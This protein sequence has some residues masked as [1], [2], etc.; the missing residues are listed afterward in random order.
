MCS[1]PATCLDTLKCETC[2]RQ[3]KLYENFL[4]GK[5]ELPVWDTGAPMLV[6]VRFHVIAS[7]AGCTPSPTDNDILAM[8]GQMNTAFAAGS[9]VFTHSIEHVQSDTWN[10]I[11]CHQEY[12]D[13]LSIP[14]GQ[15]LGNDPHAIDVYFVDQ[16]LSEGC[17]CTGAGPT[18]CVSSA[19]VS[20]FSPSLVQGVVIRNCG[21]EEV[22]PCE[23]AFPSQPCGDCP[24]SCGTETPKILV[25]EVGHY[26]DL[27]HPHETA[28][29]V[30]CPAINEANCT[31]CGDFLCDTPAEPEPSAYG[32]DP[33]SC[34]PT[35]LP[36]PPNPPCG[37]NAPYTPDL[38]NYMNQKPESALCRNHFTRGQLRRARATLL[39]LRQGELW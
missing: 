16:A 27:L 23:C 39:N 38:T 29:G 36:Q 17:T 18:V 31:T 28:F 25:H 6:N 34:T 26:F 24:P 9:I 19:G 12:L 35:N 33:Q 37:G 13:L 4:T 22:D 14:F 30:E 1:P 2:D 15:P 5:Y 10:R 7:S 11:T 3:A 20:T 32:V 21:N 8:V